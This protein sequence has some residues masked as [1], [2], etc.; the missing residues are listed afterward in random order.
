LNKKADLINS[1]ALTEQ[2]LD[3]FPNNYN[4]NKFTPMIVDD[5]PSS[6]FVGDL[7]D[8]RVDNPELEVT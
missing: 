3:E 8:D 7:L 4:N 6:V 2:V 1:I 5:M